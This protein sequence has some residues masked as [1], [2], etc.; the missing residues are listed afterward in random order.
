MKNNHIGRYVVVNSSGTVEL[1]S[2]AGGSPLSY[3]AHEAVFA[4]MMGDVIQV[5]LKNGK[6]VFYKLGPTGYSVSGP[7]MSI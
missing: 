3:F 6:T 4:I 7:Y 5:N 1:R 2:T